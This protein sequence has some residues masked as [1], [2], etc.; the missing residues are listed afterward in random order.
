MIALLVTL[1][2]LGVAQATALIVLLFRV[3]PRARRAVRL[4][5]ALLLGAPLWELWAAG[6]LLLLAGWVIAYPWRRRLAQ[7]RAVQEGR[8]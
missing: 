8:R 7:E 6:G 3:D 4:V 1:H 2:V 5:P